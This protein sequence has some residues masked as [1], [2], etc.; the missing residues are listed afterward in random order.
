MRRA[1]LVEY[2][3]GFSRHGRDTALAHRRGYRTERWSYRRLAATANQFAEELAARGV[4]P[5]DCVLLWGENCAEWVAAFLGGALAGAT[6][7]PLDRGSTGDFAARVARQVQPRL[8]VAGREQAGAASGGPPALLLEE[9]P[10]A[11]AGRSPTP[12]PSPALGRSDRLEIVFTSGTTA[13]PRGVVITHGNVL[14]NIEPLETEIRKYLRYERLVHPLRFLSLLPLSHVFGQLLGIFIPPLLG[15]AVVFEETL[16]PAQ[17]IHTIRSERVSVLVAVPRMLDSLEEKLKRDLAA[18]GTFERFERDFA[19]ATDQHFLRR[20]WRFRR[21]RRQFG[22]KFLAM[23]SG[24]AAL[25]KDSE[26]FWTRL[27]YAVIQ[28]YGLTET[29]SLISV[30]HPFALAR[31]SIGK[32]L[33]GIEMKLAEDG[34]IL[35]RGESVAA[36]YWQGQKLEPVAGEAGWFHTGDLGEL[37]AQGHLYFKGRRKNVIVTPAGMNV[38]PEDLEAELRREPEV[39]DAVVIGLERDGNAEPCAVLLLRGLAASEAT[40]K[41]GAIVRRANQRLAEYQQMRRW[42]AWPEQDFPRTPTAKPQIHLIRAVAERALGASAGAAV[43]AA[44]SLGELVA[45]ITGLPAARLRPEAQLDADLNLSSMD[46]V[47]LMSALEDRYQVELDE[48]SFARVTTLGELDRLLAA[49]SRPAALQ[50]PERG[51]LEYVYPRWA[52]RRP[53]AWLR[54]F[55]YYLLAW[56]ATLLLGYPRIRGRENL[57]GLRGPALVVSNHV[58]SIDIGFLLP[59]LPPRLRHHLATAMEGERLA[60]MRRPPAELGFFGRLYLRLQYA[61]V[62]ALFNVFPLPQHSGFRESFAYA[63]ESVGRGYSVLVF[64]EGRTTRDGKL[65]PFQAGIG[66]LSNGLRLP[67]VPMRIDGLYELRKAKRWA[68]RPGAVRV[69]IGAPAEFP[70]G[71]DPKAIARELEQRVRALEWPR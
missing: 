61:L 65:A 6:L 31:G 18:A 39:S 15:A 34:E 4:A 32:A 29:T 49:A 56:P 30:N 1:S 11:V 21:I 35:V 69:T 17:V 41:A 51:P 36:G 68:A 2:I 24:G 38:Y 20:W 40:E 13:E 14:A 27:G 50:A 71:S 54:L 37:D 9:L 5:G 66:L 10:R 70:S 46:R 45:R 57:A 55:V 53:V 60:R 43:P 28:G 63:G 22:W 33:P 64:P 58:T 62:V 42:F 8:I 47:E 3:Q 52:Q 23:I 48:S 25:A 67:V 26:T 19:R 12:F 7:V 59:A 16:N 44:G